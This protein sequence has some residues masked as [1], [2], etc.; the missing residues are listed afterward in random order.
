MAHAAPGVRPI[1]TRSDLEKLLAVDRK[2]FVEPNNWLNVNVAV[3]WVK[4]HSQSVFALFHG[5]KIVGYAKCLPLRPDVFRT[6]ISGS[7]DLRAHLTGS[8][9]LSDN[10]TMRYAS[11][12]GN[13]AAVGM[14]ILDPERKAEHDQVAAPLF[15]RMSHWF[16]AVRLRGLICQTE[17]EAEARLVQGGLRIRTQGC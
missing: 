1:T 13:Y 9:L 16:Q 6:A 12:D 4:V 15:E 14:V 5:E 2:V 8:N 11:R 3:Q 7:S 10:E 17:T